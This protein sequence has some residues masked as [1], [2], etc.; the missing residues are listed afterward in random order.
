VLVSANLYTPSIPIKQVVKY[1]I[2]FTKES[3]IRG[4]FPSFPLLNRAAG[5]TYTTSFP[6]WSGNDSAVWGCRPR[7]E[8][9]QLRLFFE[10]VV[11][12]A[13]R[14][15]EPGWVRVQARLLHVKRSA[16][17]A[18]R[19][20]E[21]E[22]KR[23]RANTSNSTVTSSERLVSWKRLPSLKRHEF[24]VRRE[25]VINRFACNN[26]IVNSARSQPWPINQR[27]G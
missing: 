22:P 27:I 9:S 20:L 4:I 10:A 5:V 13:W 17:N 15:A 16:I 26:Y 25:Y 18:E 24:W 11:N 1:M 14:C 6:S 8:R 23:T 7:F 21:R 12:F 3:L 2:V 19:R